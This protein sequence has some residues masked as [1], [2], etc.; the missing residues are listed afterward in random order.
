MRE[1][2][3]SVEYLRLRLR[4]G[5]IKRL[6]S[7]HR[8]R[9]SS[10]ERRPRRAAHHRARPGAAVRLLAGGVGLHL[11]GRRARAHRDELGLRRSRRDGARRELRRP[12]EPRLPGLSLLGLRPASS[13]G[14][15]RGSTAKDVPGLRRLRGRG[16]ERREAGGAVFRMRWEQ[17]EPNGST[18]AT[19]ARR[20]AERP[21]R[22]S[23][24]SGTA[25]SFS[26]VDPHFAA[27]YARREEERLAERLVTRMRE[28]SAREPFLTTRWR[29]SGAWDNAVRRRGHRD[30]APA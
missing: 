26:W 25:V 1:R 16:D 19:R 14:S 23:G 4:C 13:A 5:S 12:S 20:T 17:I 29:E 27:L 21:G 28:R 24:R 3:P 11:A 15:R 30:L 7:L 18:G 10:H 22:R 8:R 2:G 9:S 6:T